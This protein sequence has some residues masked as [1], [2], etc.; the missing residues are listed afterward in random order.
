MIE[1]IHTD[2]ISLEISDGSFS[3]KSTREYSSLLYEN[4]ELTKDMIK[5]TLFIYL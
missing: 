1:E 5:G 4:Y 2:S 3:T